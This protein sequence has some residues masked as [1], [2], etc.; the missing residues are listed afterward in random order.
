[1]KKLIL[2]LFTFT[3]YTHTQAQHLNWAFD[4][5]STGSSN[6]D[7]GFA[8]ARDGSGNILVTGKFEG[9]ADFDPSGSTANLTSNGNDDVF[10]AKYNSSGVY[11]WAFNI[12]GTSTD[13]GNGITTDGSD[14]VY[15]T[16]FFQGS[17][18]DFD[19]SGATNDLSSN[20]SGDIFVAKYNSSGVYQNAFN[21]G[22]TSTD[23][24]R[25][26]V[27]DNSQQAHVTG[28]FSGTA[29][30]FDPDPG[31]TTNLSTSANGDDDFF[32]AS[33]LAD[34]LNLP[35]EL[36][37]FQV[38]ALEKITRLSW[39][40]A[41]E[42]N[43]EGF[44]IEWSL[45]SRTW[46]NIGFVRGAGDSFEKQSYSF[47]HENPRAGINYYRLK[48]MDFDGA[49]EYT[50]VVSVELSV[51]GYR[52]SVSPNPTQTGTF[53]LYLPENEAETVEMTM[54]DYT[55]RVVRQM[56]LTQPQTDISVADLNTGIYLIK[57]TIG[58]EVSWARV[59]L[60]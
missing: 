50:P 23:Q 3:I 39:Q 55:G 15:V 41:S 31:T 49:F 18:V 28:W 38:R 14:N 35:V 7:R 53:T 2:L 22:G 4:V 21:I 36:L 34:A 52:L 17:N 27:V 46:Q 29:V 58:R 30:D 44:E 5:G 37:D 42:V 13:Q 10:V 11:Q 59:V 45:D 26:I 12:G 19:P 6:D 57:A 20:G 25:G 9:T 60:K 16:G 24:G 40:T 32:V 43:N 56:N 1:M 54:Y 33:F 48:Q 51:V 47:L 8:I